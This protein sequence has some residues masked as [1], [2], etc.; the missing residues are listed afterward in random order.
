MKIY[1]IAVFNSKEDA[2]AYTANNPLPSN[3]QAYYVTEWDVGR[4]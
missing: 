3:K 4:Q 2:K 1:V